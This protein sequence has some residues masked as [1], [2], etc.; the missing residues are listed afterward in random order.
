[1]INKAAKDK[2]LEKEREICHKKGDKIRVQAD[3]GSF[4]PEISLSKNLLRKMNLCQ[5]HFHLTDRFPIS[6]LEWDRSFFDEDTDCLLYMGFRMVLA[7]QS[8]F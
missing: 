5:F 7:T 2:N 1:M 8:P 4:L 6:N 3:Y